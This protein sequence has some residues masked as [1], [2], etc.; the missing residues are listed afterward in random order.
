MKLKIVLPATKRHLYETF[1]TKFPE[2][3]LVYHRIDQALVYIAESRP[4]QDTHQQI[5]WLVSNQLEFADLEQEQQEVIRTIFYDVQVDGLRV[6]D[7]YFGGIDPTK[8]N[9]FQ[10][11]LQLEDRV[12]QLHF[13]LNWTPPPVLS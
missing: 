1:A 13:P 5:A 12:M 2:L 11:L 10:V 7:I 4:P 3:Q 9:R 6:K 8:P